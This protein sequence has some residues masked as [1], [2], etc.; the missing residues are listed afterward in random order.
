MLVNTNMEK[1]INDKTTNYFKQFKDDIVEGIKDLHLPPDDLTGILTLIYNYPHILFK[2][3]DL[4]N[5][6]RI[7]NSIPLHSPLHVM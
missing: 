6:K 3:G 7:K 1:I 2:K 4:Q 5:R